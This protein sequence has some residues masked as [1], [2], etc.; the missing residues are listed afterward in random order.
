MRRRIAVLSLA[1]LFAALAL[2]QPAEACGGRKKAGKHGR[3]GKYVTY[4]GAQYG[5]YPQP[6][7]TPVHYAPSSNYAP[8][9]P[10]AP[11]APGG[12]FPPPPP[13]MM[14]S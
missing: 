13:P 11:A 5:T 14:G 3:G 1:G 7:A 2:I 10:Y 9:T 4:N 12:G 8:T 6:Q